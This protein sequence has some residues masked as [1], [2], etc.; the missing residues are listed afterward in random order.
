[1][2]PVTWSLSLLE[3]K[4][5]E[6]ILW[7]WEDMQGIYVRKESIPVSATR[8]AYNLFQCWETERNEQGPVTCFLSGIFLGRP[9]NET[10]AVGR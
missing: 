8:A 3:D 6:K 1:M 4:T 7:S 9:Q 2:G 10:I 5:I